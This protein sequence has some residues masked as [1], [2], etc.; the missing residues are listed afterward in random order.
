MTETEIKRKQKRCDEGRKA[1]K[2]R[3]EWYKYGRPRKMS[4]ED[5]AVYYIRVVNK[6]IGSLEFNEKI[7]FKK[8]YIFSICTR[9]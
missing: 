8:R 3:G 9:V 6:E 1:M 4:K 5:F 7:K 2:A